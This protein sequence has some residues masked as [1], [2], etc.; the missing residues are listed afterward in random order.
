M[1]LRLNLEFVSYSI[2]FIIFSGLKGAVEV[3]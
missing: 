2:Y 1:L 3:V